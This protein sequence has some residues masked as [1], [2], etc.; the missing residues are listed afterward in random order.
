MP[1]TQV[2]AEYKT[3]QDPDPLMP[4]TPFPGSQMLVY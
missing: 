2:P 4:S 1:G 3:P